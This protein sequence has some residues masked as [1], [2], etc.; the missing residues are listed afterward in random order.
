MP[1]KRT[2][3]LNFKT[4]D[5]KTLPAAFDVYDGASAYEVWKAQAGNAN[6]TEAQYVADMKG[7]KGDS[8]VSI[9]GVEVTIKENA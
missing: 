4:S 1:A 8:G 6:K 7:G 2:V 9:T 5:G 3:T